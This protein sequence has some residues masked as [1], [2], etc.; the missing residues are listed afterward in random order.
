MTAAEKRL[1]P[2]KYSEIAKIISERISSGVY[3]ERLP[4]INQLSV[5]FDVNRKTANRAILHLVKK[6]FLVRRAGYGTF[7]VGKEDSMTVPVL[8]RV[9]S[10]RYAVLIRSVDSFRGYL[11]LLSGCDEV[12]SAIGGSVIYAKFDDQNHDLLLGRLRFQQIEGVIICGIIANS[13]LIKLQKEFS[14][15]LIDSTP[16]KVQAN[17]IVFDYYDSAFRLGEWIAE[18]GKKRVALTS[19]IGV[20]RHDHTKTSF[21]FRLQGFRDAFNKFNIE[22]KIFTFEWSLEDLNPNSPLKDFLYKDPDNTVLV[23]L[24][25]PDVLGKL[26]SF[27]LFG[28]LLLAGYGDSLTVKNVSP[29]VYISEDYHEMGKRAGSTI[30]NIIGRPNSQFQTEI[31]TGQLLL[32]TGQ[33]CKRL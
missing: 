33:E 28:R 21:P 2:K 9:N 25:E 15:L 17:A 10:K 1:R 31:L 12:I 23:S 4:G 11:E 30:M 19:F 20:P 32:I 24:L 13:L 6:G 29:G 27:D 5:E 18:K 3:Q 14:V 7:V 22:S 26:A 16:N 8:K